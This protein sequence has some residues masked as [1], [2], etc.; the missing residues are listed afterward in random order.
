MEMKLAM[1]YFIVI[2]LSLVIGVLIIFTLAVSIL[3]I[4]IIDY[5][6]QTLALS[7]CNTTSFDIFIAEIGNNTWSSKE[8]CESYIKS[9]G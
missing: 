7:R 4:G 2:M 1:T 5:Q 9:M 3:I 6:E 8:L